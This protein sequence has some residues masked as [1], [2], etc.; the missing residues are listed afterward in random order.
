M[1]LLDHKMLP[2]TSVQQ[3]QQQQQQGKNWEKPIEDR[4]KQ[5]FTHDFSRRLWALVFRHI[6]QKWKIVQE[7]L[8]SHDLRA[9]F[10]N[11][12]SNG[13]QQEPKNNF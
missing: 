5:M 2:T 3:Q 8:I 13:N 10:P 7:K 4:A 12:S 1:L 6:C 9:S 11:N